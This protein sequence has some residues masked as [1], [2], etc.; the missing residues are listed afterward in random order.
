LAPASPVRLFS[1]CVRK[2]H[3][4]YCNRLLSFPCSVDRHENERLSHVDEYHRGT[5]LTAGRKIR[6]TH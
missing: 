3:G 2:L 5:G 1:G 4:R 6:S